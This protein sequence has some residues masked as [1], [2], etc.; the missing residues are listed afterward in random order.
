MKRILVLLALA[1]CTNVYEV[2]SPTGEPAY[3]I[4]CREASDCHAEASEICGKRGY[5]THDAS[6]AT[7]AY[8]D[9]RRVLVSTK[10]TVLVSCRTKK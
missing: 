1:G 9:S 3:S 7:R 10:T 4:E 8:A 2:R 5:V 6:E